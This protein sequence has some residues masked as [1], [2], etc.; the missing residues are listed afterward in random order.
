MET[1]TLDSSGGTALFGPCGNAD[2]G[3]RLVLNDSRLRALDVH[4]DRQL[5]VIDLSGCRTD[6]CLHLQL[7]E[8]PVLRRVY[9]P[10]GGE[11]AVVHLFA[12]TLPP[13]LEIHGAVAELDAD[14]QA[15]TFSV[16]AQQRAWPSARLL[17]Q[18][19]LAEDLAPNAG[20]EGS[21]AVVMNPR[22][23]P[24]ELTLA[25]DM[26]WLVA[27]AAR[28]TRCTV[29]GPP[30]VR[31]DDAVSLEALTLSGAG[32]VEV[33]RAAALEYAEALSGEP[34]LAK[35]ETAEA[36]EEK[37][38]STG[39][40]LTLHGNTPALSLTGGWGRVRLHAPNLA[41]L[42][43]EHA[44]RLAL[45]YCRYLEDVSLPDDQ[46]V[47]CYGSV[48]APLLHR[49]RFV[50]DEATLGQ[51]LTRVEDGE[52]DLL[53]GLLE[54]MA[55][56][57]T[58]H[59][60]FH[61][62]ASLRRLAEKGVDPERLWQCRRTLS[63]NQCRSSRKRKQPGLAEAHYQH[64]DARWH[65]TFPDDRQDEGLRDDLHLWAICAPHSEAARRYG[66]TLRKAVYSKKGR[67]DQDKLV[68][69]L[70]LATAESAPQAIAELAL[71]VLAKRYGNDTLPGV[72][73]AREH[74][75]IVG[76]LPRLLS[77][78]GI[79]EAEHQAVLCATLEMTSGDDLAQRAE[80][81]LRL[82]PGQT[83]ALLMTLSRQPD[84]WLSR[85][86]DDT[87]YLPLPAFMRP[88]SGVSAQEARQIQAVRQTLMQL[89]LMPSSAAQA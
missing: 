79:S 62:L 86:L 5:E 73:L 63:A 33:R 87:A 88:R 13:T 35:Q 53:D 29:A 45:H 70:R 27:N 44:D 47:D 14:W 51:T 6:A 39:G 41:R 21:L 17:G 7:S 56:A 71:S 84:T 26:Q 23:L 61:S 78:P 48:P 3:R 28:V 82:A 42:A 49:A 89:A 10:A 83:R 46:E 85:Y 34:A 12:L 52:T 9:L 75:G 4:G 66:V 15:G 57:E 1:L 76:Y 77:V 68:Q 2:D 54:A 80:Q 65:W 30:R 25:G 72:N 11:G 8:L 55:R 32:K 59:A 58:P 20:T 24:A 40:R 64:A 67:L 69:I 36:E 81:L 74:E 43:L 18:D 50:I 37:K 19:A 16:R 60:V 38:Y 22:V 31:L